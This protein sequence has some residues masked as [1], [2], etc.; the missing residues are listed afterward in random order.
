M[1]VIRDIEYAAHGPQTSL[2][3]YLA[4]GPGPLYVYFH[5]GGFIA[6]DKEDASA[7]LELLARQGISCI[8]ANYRLWR[9]GGSEQ[10]PFFYGDAAAVVAWA[11]RGP[12]VWLH[13]SAVYRRFVGGRGIGDDA[14]F[15]TPA[16]GGTGRKRGGGGGLG[17]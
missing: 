9:K 4:G 6:G 17:V 10:E 2:D 13:R 3:F 8:S 15:C 14:V 7:G 5:D 1:R 16:F 11:A 12:A